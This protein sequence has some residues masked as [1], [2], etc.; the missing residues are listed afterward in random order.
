MRY[1]VE[2]Y[3]NPG[4]VILDCYAGSGTTR[5]A[6]KQTG[7]HYIGIEKEQRYADTAKTRL[8]QEMWLGV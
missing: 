1:L 7:R 5:V 8:I 6:C 2:T 4:D 3:T